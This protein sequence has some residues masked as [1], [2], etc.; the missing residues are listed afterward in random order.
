[1]NVLLAE[2][3]PVY[4]GGIRQLI[5]S[6]PKLSLV[7]ETGN[8][9]E[10]LSEL[11]QAKIDIAVLDINMP[12]IGGIEIARARIKERLDF[13]IIFLTMFHERD[14]FDEALGLGVNGFVL[15]ESEPDAILEAIKTVGA[16]GSWFSPSMVDFLVDRHEKSGELRKETPGLDSLS[17][18]EQR[19]LKMVASNMTTKEISEAL[20]LSP[21]T[22]DNH[23]GNISAKLGLKGSHSLLRFA[24]ENRS[25]L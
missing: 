19:I 23:R 8:G 22:I 11:R 18:S 7:F 15:K 3:H 1:M 6:E 9:E 2:D 16:G 25:I 5:E 14:I 10:A 13:K 4:R 17:D 20:D 21:R 12:G 24:F